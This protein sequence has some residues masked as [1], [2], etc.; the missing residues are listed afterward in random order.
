MVLIFR[1]GRTRIKQDKRLIK[2]KLL[3]HDYITLKTLRIEV[4]TCINVK[5][6]KRD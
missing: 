4:K 2:E 3:T 1:R 5:I 6:A